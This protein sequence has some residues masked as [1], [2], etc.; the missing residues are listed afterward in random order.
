MIP[1]AVAFKSLMAAEKT[2]GILYGTVAF[3]E[4]LVFILTLVV[5]YIYVWKK[6]IFDWGTLARAEAREEAK[7][8]AKH[9][10]DVRDE[11]A[12]IKIAA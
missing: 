4:I 1:F 12:R 3:V 6:G 5:G 7:Q 9:R 10:R 8:L 2:S 11:A